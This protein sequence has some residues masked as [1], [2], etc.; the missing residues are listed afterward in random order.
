MASID[1]TKRVFALL[2]FKFPSR[3]P[4]KEEE[5]AFIFEMWARIFEQVSDESLLQ[6]AGRFMAETTRIFPTDDPLAMILEMAQRKNSETAGDCIE[7][8]SEAV[9][10]FGYMREPQAMA[11]VAEK[12]ELCAAVLRRFGFLA[13]CNAENE[14][15]A[16]G[17][18][19]R[20]YDEEK[21]R[22]KRTGQVLGSAT[23]LKGGETPK[24]AGKLTNLVEHLA[25]RRGLKN[26]N[27]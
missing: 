15:V 23:E 3:R 14:E 19:R 21:A 25:S 22:F 1:T 11:W 24:L 6:A 18:L 27:Q 26:A 8:A 13:F 17:Q 4:Q 16:R 2:F 7:L 9:R 10:K 12:S 20:I 5:F